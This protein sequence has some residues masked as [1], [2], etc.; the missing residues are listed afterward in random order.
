MSWRLNHPNVHTFAVRSGDVVA[1]NE[2]ARETGDDPAQMVITG[3]KEAIKA[4]EEEAQQHEESTSS[5]E[6]PDGSSIGFRYSL[7]EPRLVSNDDGGVAGMDFMLPPEKNRTSTKEENPD[8]LSVFSVTLS[9]ELI[10]GAARVYSNPAAIFNDGLT[11]VLLRKIEIDNLG[12]S[13]EGSDE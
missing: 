6:K 8:R 5:F 9:D 10:E 13:F 3:M 2:L 4:R 12:D 7:D 11:R 1:L